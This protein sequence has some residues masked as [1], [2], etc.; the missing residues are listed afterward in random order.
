MEKVKFATIT[1]IPQIVAFAYRT[2]KGLEELELPAPDFT[3]ITLE[4]TSWLLN[5]VVLVYRDHEDDVEIQ[6]VLVGEIG[7]LWWT[8]DKMLRTSLFA[9]NENKSNSGRIAISLVDALKQYSKD[10]NTPVL[11][12]IIDK[13]ENLTKVSRFLNIKGFKNFSVSGIYR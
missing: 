10:I 11:L 12:D 3:K 13:E 4:V 6:G 2:Y 5:D 7:E 8:K 9:V 1:D